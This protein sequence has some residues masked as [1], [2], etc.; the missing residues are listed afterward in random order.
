MKQKPRTKRKGRISSTKK[1]EGAMAVKL[2]AV[3]L[4]FWTAAYPKLDFES[5][6]KLLMG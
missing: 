3:L 5:P 6:I 1:G 2:K 4:N